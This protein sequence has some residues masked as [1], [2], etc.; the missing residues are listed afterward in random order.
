LYSGT[1]VQGKV[2]LVLDEE[3]A[4]V[5]TCPECRAGTCTGCKEQAHDG[6]TCSM[7]RSK[8]QEQNQKTDEQSVLDWV[9][10]DPKKRK[11]CPKCR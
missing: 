5:F 8:K 3:N 6:M 11:A 10:A 4:E 1:K 9:K 7:L 2:L